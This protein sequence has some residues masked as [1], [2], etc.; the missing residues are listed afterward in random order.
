MLIYSICRRRV[1][2]CSAGSGFHLAG[3]VSKVNLVFLTQFELNFEYEEAMFFQRLQ[4][5]TAAPDVIVPAS[6][7]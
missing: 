7:F 5:N 2:L 1:S 4:P 6:N 3:Y